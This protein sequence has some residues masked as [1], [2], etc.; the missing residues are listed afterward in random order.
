MATMTIRMTDAKHERLRR[1]AERQGI[2]VNK[3]VEE[4]ANVALAQHDAEIRFRTLAAR[5]SA[6]RGI[7]LLDKLDEALADKRT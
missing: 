7:A 6:R 5:G 2:S 3:L 4:W 1:L